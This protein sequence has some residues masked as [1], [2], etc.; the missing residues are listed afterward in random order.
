[1]EKPAWLKK[2]I[3]KPTTIT[4]PD[5]YEDYLSSRR[6]FAV[7]APLE[8]VELAVIDG[9]TT[10]LDIKQD[11]LISLGGLKVRRNVVLI[12]EQFEGYLRVPAV[13]YGD[14]GSVIIHGILPRS[15]RYT[16]SSPEE[17]LRK[18]LAYV[19]DSVIVGHHIG[20]DVSMINRQLAELGAGP[21][22]N[23]VVDTA[24]IARQLAPA[25][26]WSPKD[27][28]TL[29]SLARRYGVSLSDRHTAMGDAFITALLLLKLT[30]RL[31]ERRGRPLEL[32]DL[33]PSFT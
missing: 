21:L 25:G 11:R 17:L 27:H 26:Y 4:Y 18:F 20:F 2:L 24:T 32:A 33:Q 5:W 23:P 8:D 28:Y 12:G 13:N 19:G 6:Q 10:G 29:D 7:S 1:M 30:A 14:G 3:G 22:V 9:E 16:Y 15:E 31:R